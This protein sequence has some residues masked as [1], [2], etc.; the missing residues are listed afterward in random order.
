M[1]L[2]N[3][4]G[5]HQDTLLTNNTFAMG[6]IQGGYKAFMQCLQ[7]SNFNYETDTLIQLGDIVDGWSEIYECVEEL[8]K[9]KNLIAI[10]GNHDDWALKWME[11]GIHPGRTQGGDATIYSYLKNCGGAEN[12]ENATYIKVPEEHLKFF[13]YQ[14]N[15]YIDDENR[16][17]IHGGFNRHFHIKEQDHSIFYWDRDFWA[18][19]LTY[20][21]ISKKEG[22]NG[23]KFKIKDQFKE[24]F[25]G[26]TSTTNWSVNEVK[27]NGIVMPGNRSIDFP[28]KAANVYNMDT[29][30]GF[31]GRLTIMNVDTKEYWQS[32]LLTDL[33]PNEKG[34]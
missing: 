5:M 29:G 31:K 4:N 9:I 24:V 7:R 6:D 25:I 34:R 2:I 33:Y 30:A 14:H 21:N 8:L 23:G 3:K 19:A 16:L 26:H 32:D 20:E 13:K 22:Y 28:M 17:F 1:N 18:S 12:W 15:Y 10:K 27:V 11:T